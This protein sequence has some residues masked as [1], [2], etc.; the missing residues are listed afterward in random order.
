VTI[1][2]DRLDPA[3]GFRAVIALRALADQME[4]EIVAQAL[5]LGWSWTLIG[6]ALNVSRQAAQKK[7]APLFGASTKSK[8]Q[9]V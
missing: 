1:A 8:D 7:H 3:D 5:G 6:E 2:I 9:H 4:S